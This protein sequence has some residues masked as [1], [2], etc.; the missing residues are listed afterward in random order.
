M[1]QVFTIRRK[2]DPL[3]LIAKF[4][5]NESGDLPEPIKELIADRLGFTLSPDILFEPTGYGENP[6]L[7]PPPDF[8]LKDGREIWLYPGDTSQ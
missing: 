6:N 2:S 1:A 3:R 4:I 7:L 8:K 5:V